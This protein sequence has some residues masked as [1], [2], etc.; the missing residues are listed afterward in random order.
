M[1]KAQYPDIL[2]ASAAVLVRAEPGEA[3]TPELVTRAL[4]NNSIMAMAETPYDVIRADLDRVH[5][6]DETGKLTP[7]ADR[8]GEF[9]RRWLATRVKP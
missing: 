3:L 9:L 4:A 7:V 1:K 8:Y 2:D 6:I 5:F